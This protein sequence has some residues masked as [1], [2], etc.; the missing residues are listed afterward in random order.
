MEGK[1]TKKEIVAEFLNEFDGA[2]GNDDGI[3]TWKEWVDYYTDLSMGIAN[4]DYFIQMMESVWQIPEKEDTAS[5]KSKID[6]LTGYVKEQLLTLSAAYKNKEEAVAKLFEDFDLNMDGY[7]TI[8]ELTAM[9][10]KLKISMERKM[11]TGVFRNINHSNSGAIS[12][13]EFTIFVLS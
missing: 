2:K 7:L 11:A 8:D 6:Q 3:V 12:A 4:D 10:A 1:K 9:V 5:Y 13:E